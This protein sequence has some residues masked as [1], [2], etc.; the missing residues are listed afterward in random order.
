MELEVEFGG[1]TMKTVVYI[2]MDAWKQLLLSEG[3]C[4]QL[5]LVMY[6][7]DVQEWCGDKNKE[8]MDIALVP[9]VRTKL[10]SKLC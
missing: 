10:Y 4:Q 7:L 6:H 8:P 2:K 9:L 5:G 3:V 1:K